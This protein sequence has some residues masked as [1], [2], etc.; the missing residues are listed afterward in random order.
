MD[1]KKNSVDIRRKM[2]KGAFWLFLDKGAQQLAGFL[3][4]AIVARLLGPEEYGLVALCNI[5]IF[6]MNNVT[7]GL[8]DAVIS[9][10]L[11]DN[12]R[13]S[14]L[15]WTVITAGALLSLCS[16]GISSS[17][18]Q[19]LGQPRIAS[20]LQAFSVMPFLFALAAVPTAL[21]TA[22]MDFRV[23]TIRTLFASLV[24][25]ATGIFCAYSGWGAYAL[26]TQQI[27]TQIAINIVVWISSD[28]RPRLLFSVESM[29]EI[30]KLGLGQTGTYFLTFLDSQAPRFLLGYFLGPAAVG[31]YSFI[32][33]IGTSIQDGIIQPVLGVV[34][35]AISNIVEDNK[36]KKILVR[37]TLFII[38]AIMS[39]V[40]VG[41]I[42]TAPIFI[43]LF[44]G[45]KWI[46]T[47]D[48]VQLFA[49]TT[50]L[51][52]INVT[53]RSIMRAHRQIGTYFRVHAIV[54]FLSIIGYA[55][56]APNGFFTVI[57]VNAFASFISIGIF[58]TMVLKKTEINMFRNYVILW[59]PVISAL[60]MGAFILLLNKTG[61][62]PT[63]LAPQLIVTII[64]GVA[65]YSLVFFSIER[66]F[67]RKAF[68]K[69][70]S[71]LRKR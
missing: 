64:Y 31:Y 60:A 59:S 28:W 6:L 54:V 10:R 15:F 62:I 71:F 9:M 23:F 36:Q 43:P 30:L 53:L 47:I 33:R 29:G 5:I 11:R 52:S 16:F 46:L 42:L 65:S 55:F 66:T 25:G 21:I 44:F 49:V 7:S 48:G 17:F 2:A 24:G 45:E 40:V 3:V 18:A 70:T 39:P 57:A 19:M 58:T 26:V 32:I 38:G 51:F 68:K 34:Y 22:T 69:L 37:Q 13:L 4:F 1:I 8:V 56:A 50:F 27:V 14:S 61:A 12:L 20:L 67:A 63:S 41:I 35:P